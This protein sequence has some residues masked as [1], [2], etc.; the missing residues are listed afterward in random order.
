M[1]LAD[2]FKALSDPQRRE[3]LQMLRNG[4]M[5]AGGIAEALNISAAALS[6]HL[7]QLKKADM[8]LEYK[9]KNYIYFELNSTLFD[10]MILWLQRFG[11]NDGKEANKADKTIKPKRHDTEK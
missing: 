5:T 9:H 10:D 3:I 11:E 1:G 6:Y 8:I 7:N 2:S 4:R